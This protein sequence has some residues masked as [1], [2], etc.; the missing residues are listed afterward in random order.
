MPSEKSLPD[1]LRRLCEL[2]V[3]HAY[4]PHRELE[5]PDS[6]PNEG[7]WMSVDLL[8]LYGTD[9]LEE[10][11]K[12]QLWKLSRY[13]LANF[14]SLT[15][16]GI[17]D[18]MQQV[19]SCIY[20]TGYEAESD[21]FHHFL[22]EENK[23]MWFFAEFCKRYAGKIYVTRKM[24]FP[25]FAE[26]DIQTF[27][28]FAKILISEQIGDFYNMRMMRDESLPAI[29]QKL[30]RVHHEDEGRH[31]AMGRRLVREMY[32]R[33]SE[34]YSEQRRREIVE[35]LRRYMEFFVSSFYNPGVYRDADL[36]DPYE[37]RRT[38][39]RHP[40]RKKFHRQALRTTSRFFSI[41]DL[42]LEGAM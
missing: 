10:L 16:H 25:S 27:I 2:S 39:I 36:D 13:E 38:L 32:M 28:A 33:I 37:L 35:Y 31:I 3:E 21:Y 26:D 22:D 19:L 15:V 8:S 18:L 41:H 7:V 40:A 1:L 5:W 23:H 24:Q 30:N 29:V 9:C 6:L 34:K 11:T 12:E 42:D 20:N 17:R 14:F 4:D